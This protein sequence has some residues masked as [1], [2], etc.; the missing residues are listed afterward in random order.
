MS[1]RI[2]KSLISR[3]C[4][5]LRSLSEGSQEVLRVLATLPSS[6]VDIDLLADLVQKPPQTVCNLLD[7]AATIGA[8]HIKRNQRVQFTHDKHHQAALELIT[9]QQKSTLYVTI[10]RK[11][12]DKGDDY[13]FA[14]AEL[15]T[16]IDAACHPI[17]EKTRIRESVC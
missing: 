3:C 14:R 17:F 9:E 10:F 16:Q 4:S 8:I 2:E 7:E 15:A 11:L 13:I 1:K 6:G 5:T 12:E